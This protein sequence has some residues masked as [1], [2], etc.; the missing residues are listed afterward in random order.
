MATTI[1][2]TLKGLVTPMGFNSARKPNNFTNFSSPLPQT[3]NTALNTPAIPQAPAS[4]PPPSQ[5]FSPASTP[6]API[7]GLLT[8]DISSLSES[9]K[10][11]QSGL[12]NLQK[13]REQPFAAGNPGIFGNV[14]SSLAQRSTQVSPETTKAL[15]DAAR[16]REQAAQLSKTNLGQQTGQ[17]TTGT[18]PVAEG[19]AQITATMNAQQQQALAAQQQAALQAAGVGQRQQEIEQAALTGAAGFAAPQLSS[20][21]QGFYNP[22][23]PTGGAAGGGSSALNPLN[24]VDSLAQQVLNGQISPQMA[25]AMGG[26]VPN[27]QGVLNQAILRQNPNANVASLQGQ[28]DAR[29]QS[30]TIAGVAPSQAFSGAYQQFYPQVL[31]LQNQL[32]NVDQLGGLLLSTAQGGQINPFAPQLANRTIAQFRGQLSDADQ[33]KFNSTLAAFQ[34][35]ASQLLASSSGQ[36]PTDVSANIAAISNGSL[37]LAALKAMV[38]QASMEGQIKLSNIQQATN[39]AGAGIGA[40]TVGGAAGGSNPLGI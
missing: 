20:F 17:L 3:S 18:Q 22:L 30:T 39:T 10:G 15:E 28:F 16:F 5:S 1:S 37:S 24:N 29:Q 31:E 26:N 8:P 4:S 23:D 13:E 38:E 27:F 6:P 7:K 25:Y 36:I 12:A 19:T 14:V 35:A 9:L 34:G 40:P 32:S 11:I 2:N 33:A 21:G